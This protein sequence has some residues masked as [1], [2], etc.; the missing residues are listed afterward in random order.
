[1]LYEKGPKYICSQPA[2]STQ[3]NM[4]WLPFVD[5]PHAKGGVLHGIVVECGTHDLKVPGSSPT[6]S[7]V[8][9]LGSFLGQDTS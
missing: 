9:F 5:F 4:V 7:T 6:G 3:A 2:Q 1:M 8:F